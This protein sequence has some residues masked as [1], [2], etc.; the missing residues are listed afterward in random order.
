MNSTI[1]VKDHST[2]AIF[3]G[4]NFDPEENIEICFQ[5]STTISQWNVA[6]VES[7]QNL[8]PQNVGN[9]WARV[10]GSIQNGC[11]T[12]QRD[13]FDGP[14]GT[15]YRAFLT[16]HQ[17]EKEA[18]P[19]SFRIGIE[20]APS[21]TPS[22]EPSLSTVPTNRPSQNHSS[23]PSTSPNVTPSMVPSSTTMPTKMPSM[24]PSFGPSLSTV[25]SK[26]P[27]VNPSFGPTLSNEP[28]ESPSTIPSPEPSMTPSVTLSAVPSSSPS[29]LPSPEPSTLPT[30]AP[31]TN[32]SLSCDSDTE[33]ERIQEGSKTVSRVS[34]RVN[35]LS[36]ESSI[37]PTSSISPYDDYGCFYH[38]E[39]QNVYISEPLTG[40]DK[41][42]DARAEECY[43]V[44]DTQHFAIS[45]TTCFCYVK[46]PTTRLTI[47]SCATVPA[48]TC[49]DK[50]RII[51]AY[52]KK[53]SSIDCNQE[54]TA[55][56][57]DQFVDE[58]NAPRGYDITTN[59]VR[60]SSPF[61]LSK[62]ECGTNI[63]EIQTKVT[64]GTNTLSTVSEDVSD[65]ASERRR[66]LANRITTSASGSAWFK[67]VKVAVRVMASLDTEVND[68][69]KYS[70][71]TTIGSKI[72][73]SFGAKTI[74]EFKIIDFD[75]R[76]NFVTFSEQFGSALRDY[77][78]SGFEI[79]KAKEIF[80]E[81]GM[82][83]VERGM[84]GGF[85]YVA[86]QIAW[87]KSCYYFFSILF[88]IFIEIIFI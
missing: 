48:D 38:D 62:D 76:F 35:H 47:G 15:S 7:A 72:F 20:E 88:I 68:I 66:R 13:L 70:G 46:A 30:V 36:S 50:N 14:P 18:D 39:G 9:K 28:S 27:S 78:D 65:F 22:S 8:E 19:V 2:K 40:H 37:L 51:D 79:E 49:L 73:T 63:Y 52:L 6:I 64:E 31:S 59:S 1:T 55:A 67:F 82:F 42:I 58:D 85:R 29:T 5:G 17:L 69:M 4:P 77:R 87:I 83:V 34:N 84:F 60:P 33:I 61:L 16:T 23:K 3:L 74:A 41:P 26:V 75:N 71:S 57:R 12:F 53:A 25:P 11:V 80:D 10:C 21:E 24:I 54:N 81:Y 44:C 32:P 43:D 45:D 56:V 86:V